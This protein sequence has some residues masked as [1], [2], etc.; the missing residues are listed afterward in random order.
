MDRIDY[1][2]LLTEKIHKKVKEQEVE[3][4][5]LKEQAIKQNTILDL[6]YKEIKKLRKMVDSFLE[7]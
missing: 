2:A 4:K 1:N 5:F 6:T 3:I 7:R